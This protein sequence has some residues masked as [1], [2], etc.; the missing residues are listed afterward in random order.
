MTTETEPQPKKSA[1][2]FPWWEYLIE[3]VI[4]ILG[5]YL[6]FMANKYQEAQKE[7]RYTETVIKEMYQSLAS[8]IRDAKL[9]EDGHKQGLKSVA[10]FRRMA[11][12]EPVAVDSFGQY[13]LELTRSFVSIQNTASFEALKSTGL[14]VISNDSLRGKIVHVYDFQYDILEKVEEE[15]PESHL[16]EHHYH[17]IVD[18]LDKALVLDAKGKLTAIRTPLPI[19]S[20]ERVRLFLHLGRIGFA[21]LFNLSVYGSVIPEMERL[22]AALKKEYGYLK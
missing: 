17:D 5:I 4:L 14:D 21:R 13:S 20:E 8:D 3:L 15:Y 6:G 12:G 19:T 7:Q 22:R 10:Y 18:I 16:L 9:N 1:F 11:Q 2:R